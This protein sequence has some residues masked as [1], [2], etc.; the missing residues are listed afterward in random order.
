MKYFKEYE[1]VVAIKEK[2]NGNE[3][4]GDMWV[5]TKSFHKDSKI[6]DVIEWAK[7]CSGKLVITIDE[8]LKLNF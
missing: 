2:S 3:S 8:P 1:K 6:E 4:V 5:E 7:D